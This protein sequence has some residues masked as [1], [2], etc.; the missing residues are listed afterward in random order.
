LPQQAPAYATTITQVHQPLATRVTTVTQQPSQQLIFF[1][2][3]KH[4]LQR[5]YILLVDKSGSMAGA[6]WR[7]AKTAVAMIA[8]SACHCDPDGITL[9]FFSSPGHLKKYTNIKNPDMVTA[10]FNKEK[11]GGTTD[12]TGA[13]E[14][15]LNEHFRGKPGTQ[16]T[17][18]VI[19]DGEPDN[20]KSVKRV[21]EHASNKLHRDEDLSISFVQVGRDRAASKYLKE[22]DDDLQCRF[23]IVDTLPADALKTMSFE[24]FIQLSIND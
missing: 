8:P 9:Y 19:T 20:R 5:D 21:I 22:L 4:S 3:V 13:L 12:L 24:Q 7:E 14:A 16:T 17:I 10:C 23:D 6:N 18:L 1:Q 15:A 11:P 2:H